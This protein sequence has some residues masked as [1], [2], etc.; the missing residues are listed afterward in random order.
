MTKFLGE[1]IEVEKDKISPCP[2]SFKWRDQVYTVAKVLQ[3]WVD[4][5]FGQA[6]PRSCKWYN[7]RHRRHYIVLCESGETFEMYYD[8]GDKR[9]H[10]WWLV[11]QM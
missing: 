8:Y 3:E 2:V 6:P 5:S 11:R 7:R 9:Q 1:K 4:S 10:T